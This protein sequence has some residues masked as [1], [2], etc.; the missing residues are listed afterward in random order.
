VEHL[1]KRE[2][3]ERVGDLELV[4]VVEQGDAAL[5]IYRL[6]LAA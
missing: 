5:S 1:R 2:L 3:A 4:R 6:A